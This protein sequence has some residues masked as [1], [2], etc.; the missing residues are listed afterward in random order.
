MDMTEKKIKGEVLFEGKVVR[1]EKDEVLCPNGAIS[2]REVV[3]HNGG[4]AILCITKDNKVLLER[5]F[6]YPY[7]E[8]IYEIPAGKLEKGE[9]PYQAALRELEEETG[10]KAESLE[11][12]TDVYPTCGYSN[13]IIHLYL[14]NNCVKTKTHLDPDEVIETYYVPMDDVKK[15]ISD[16]R[17]KDAKTICA[18]SLY[19]LKYNK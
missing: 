13:E 10:L 4:A 3:R 11:H 16:G 8:V 2:Y 5:Q 19:N 15:M 12:L 14:A 7:D 1:L 6:R 9:D 17:I 18:L